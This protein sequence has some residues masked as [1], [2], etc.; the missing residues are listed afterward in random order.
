MSKFRFFVTA[1]VVSLCTSL[2]IARGYNEIQTENNKVYP[3][4][5]EHYENWLQLSKREKSEYLKKSKQAFKGD[6]LLDPMPRVLNGEE[7]DNVLKKGVEQRA[8]A[9]I[10][11][12][13][14]HYSGAR[15]Y[16]KAGV[17]SE[18]TVQDIIKRTADHP[19]DQLL[20]DEKIS[21]IYGPDIIRDENG[22][23]RIIEDNSGFVGGLGDLVL[24]QDFYLNYFPNLSENFS[25]RDADK[26]YDE[27]ARLYKK[28]AKAFN[29]EVVLYM[30]PPYAD[31]EDKR[32]RKLL[33]DRGIKTITPHTIEQLTVDA[34]GVYTINTKTKEKTKVGLVMLNGEHWWLDANFEGNKPRL[35]KNTSA[36]GFAMSSY[37][38]QA[39]HTSGLTEAILQNKVA[40]NYTPGTDFIGDKELYTYVEDFIHFYLDEDP[41]IRNIPTE[42]FADKRTGALRTVLLNKVLSNIDQFVIKTVDGRGGDGVWVG[43]KVD[44]KELEQLKMLIQEKPQA[45][46][47][48]KYTPLSTMNDLIVD[49]RI[50]TIVSDDEIY[51][52]DTPWGRGLPANGN[53]K[54]NL[55]DNGREITVL[56]A[57]KKKEKCSRLLKK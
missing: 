11:F 51:V 55:S 22:Q 3:H 31:N 36:S 13:K 10:A 15:E 44:S 8:R 1:L 14:D 40:C 35:E 12:L 38:K 4:Y 56:V 9:L 54:V 19:Y 42:S 48:Q 17:I 27:L 52:S 46:I 29:G 49:L 20:K 50:L 37:L 21:F 41:I 5:E 47:V 33:A 32:V 6:N 26:F 43:P 57:D 25:Y 18:R 34:S 7:Y 24:A 16:L 23:W 39:R 45:F 2:A 28:R 53:G 30:A